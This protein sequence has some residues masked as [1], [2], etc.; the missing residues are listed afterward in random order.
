MILSL[1]FGFILGV[2]IGSLIHIGVYLFLALAIIAGMFF[3]Y[4]YFVEGVNR[5]FITLCSI[6]LLAFLFGVLRVNFS[7]LYA[8]SNLIQYENKKVTAVG[9]VAD[10]PDVREQNVKLTVKL[11]EVLFKGQKNDVSEKILITVPLYPEFSYGDKIEI[12]NLKLEKAKNIESDDGRIFD[13]GGYL[14]V[15]GIWYT[16][17]YVQ[18]KFVDS[19]HGAIIKSILF[20]IKHAFVSSLDKAL[21]LPESSYMTGLLLGAKQSLGKDLLYEFQRTGTSHVVVL[22]GYNIAIVAESIMAVLSFLPKTLSFSFG[23][24]SIILFTLLSG[25]GASAWRAA[26]MVLVALFAKKMNRDYK[27][28]RALGFAIV[29]M[30]APNP[31]LLVFDPSFQLSILAT[32]GLIFVSPYVEPYLKKVPEKFG[33]KEIIGSTIATQVTVLPFLIY[34]TGLISTVSLPVNILILGTIPLTMFLG[35]VTGIVGIISLWFSFIPAFFA[36]ILLWYQLKVVHIGSSIPLGAIK[37]PAFSFSTL[38]IIY[39]IIFWILFFIKKRKLI[40]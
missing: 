5:L 38:I 31:L 32:I 7:N 14:R 35:F 25:G 30:L 19:G 20:K 26:I 12:S 13:Y 10:E 9:I 6:V 27:A 23:T 37:I 11:S 22:S 18:L 15:R 16:A 34:N 28:S 36:Y 3:V 33:L 2:A 4:R 1:I 8:T 24:I 17:N 21:P 29:F 39:L 40:L